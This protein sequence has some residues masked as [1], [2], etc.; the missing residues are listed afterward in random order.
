M[1]D[2]LTVFRS[3]AQPNSCLILTTITGGFYF[4]LLFYL[5]HPYS[6]EEPICPAKTVGL[7]SGHSQWIQDRSYL[8]LVIWNA[9]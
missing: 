6:D 8:I 3:K 1:P 4:V 7:L 2:V 5:F 9:F